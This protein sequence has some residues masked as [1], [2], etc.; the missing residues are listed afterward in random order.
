MG[1]WELEHFWGV[2]REEGRDGEPPSMRLGCV[3]ELG[4][5]GMNRHCKVFRV[6]HNA[7]IS[8]ASLHRQT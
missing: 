7:E 6:P 4:S 2:V 1:A 5:S 3:R 8:D